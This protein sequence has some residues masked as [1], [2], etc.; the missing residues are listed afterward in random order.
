MSLLWLWAPPQGYASHSLS[1][2]CSLQQSVS[3]C[4]S[5]HTQGP[6]SIWV[7]LKLSEWWLGLQ[8]GVREGTGEGEVASQIAHTDLPTHLCS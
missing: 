5:A 6:S 7:E 8:S 2:S 3:V 1:G 4:P